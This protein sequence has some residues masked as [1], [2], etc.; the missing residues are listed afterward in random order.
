MRAAHWSGRQAAKVLTGNNAWW[1]RAAD[2]VA[3]LTEAATPVLMAL[4][5]QTGRQVLAALPSSLP[6]KSRK[7]DE[8]VPP[9]LGNLVPGSHA[10]DLT[11]ALGAVHESAI[12]RSADAVAD[13]LGLSFQLPFDVRDD[14]LTELA[15]RIGGIAD[16]T[17]DDVRRIVQR[18]LADGASIDQLRDDLRGL[19][20]ET[21]RN[22]SRTIAR[23]ES[24]TAYNLG[25]VASYRESGIVEQVRVHDGDD[26]EP[27]RS[28]N[29]SAWSLDEAQANPIGH[30]NCIRAFAPLVEPLARVRAAHRTNG[31]AAPL[32]VGRRL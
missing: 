19:F 5:R 8:P 21:Y 23:T 9:A 10:A 25:S 24:G 14:L 22:R 4:F 12:D 3:D 20:T 6:T 28:A 29:G 26:D 2:D 7:A 27:C 16:A 15:G 11:R 31:H 18:A 30:P 17:R 32:L 1:G 13:G